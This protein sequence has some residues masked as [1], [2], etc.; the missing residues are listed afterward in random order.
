[1][2]LTLSRYDS[3]LVVK[4]ESLVRW[5]LDHGANPNLGPPPFESVPSQIPRLDSGYVLDAVASSSTVG[6][7]DLLLAYGAKLE[8]SLALHWAAQ[9][10]E[11]HGRIPMMERLLELGMDING[12]DVVRGPWQYGTPL[13][14]ASR[15]GRK[16]RVRFLK[17]RGA[18]SCRRSWWIDR[19]I[20][21]SPPDMTDTNAPSTSS[22]PD[23]IDM[24]TPSTNSPPDMIDMNTPSSTYTLNTNMNTPASSLSGID[25][26][27]TP[28]TNSPP[29]M[30]DM[31]TP[32]STYEHE[33]SYL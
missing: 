8:N 4:D 9:A 6:V 15:Y 29:D 2:S 30:I 14:Y 18:I 19:I 16:E 13:D 1:M 3:R 12:S 26:I 33:H 11:D 25:N 24:N 20:P 28:N 27:N 22:P 7:L 23:V 32:S 10:S 21:N 5:F 17:E 31:N